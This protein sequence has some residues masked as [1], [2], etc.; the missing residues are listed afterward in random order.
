MILTL[1]DYANAINE[2]RHM[3]IQ[4][5]EEI[6]R[7]YTKIIEDGIQERKEMNKL[8]KA[9]IQA[10]ENKL[11]KL[12]DQAADTQQLREEM[13]Q[14]IRT[15]RQEYIK[16]QERAAKHF[17]QQLNNMH[18]IIV[19]NTEAARVSINILM[20]AVAEI[21]I[22]LNDMSQQLSTYLRNQ[23]GLIRYHCEKIIRVSL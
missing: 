9:E 18:E 6:E 21:N 1:S 2:Q 5:R 17:Q 16:A 4:H 12:D 15:E 22:R 14:R 20:S 10:L 13:E 3:A 7:R 23:A 11:D 19:S 8:W